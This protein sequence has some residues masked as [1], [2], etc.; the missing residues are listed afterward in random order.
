MIVKSGLKREKLEVSELCLRKITK[1][2][3]DEFNEYFCMDNVNLDA[4]LSSICNQFISELQKVLDTVVPEKKVKLLKA[5]R[6]PWYDSDLKEQHKIVR[7]CE[8]C[9]IKYGINSH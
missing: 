2:T 8:R 5:R 9:C 3:P 6:T 7:N 1:V 4:E